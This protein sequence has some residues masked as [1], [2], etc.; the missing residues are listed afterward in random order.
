MRVQVGPKKKVLVQSASTKSDSA[1]SEV[2]IENPESSAVPGS[3]SVHG[4][5]LTLAD[6][7]KGNGKISATSLGKDLEKA[8]HND[9][10]RPA[11]KMG[12]SSII[13]IDEAKQ[14]ISEEILSVL[15]EKFNG[16]L[17]AVRPVDPKDILF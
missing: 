9:V 2:Q 13:T 7:F 11:E 12:E 4:P 3:D 16:K 5:G 15:A 1:R 8:E 17:S 14:Q 6:E 10:L